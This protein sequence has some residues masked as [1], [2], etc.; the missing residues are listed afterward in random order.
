TYVPQISNPSNDWRLQQNILYNYAIFRLAHEEV[1]ETNYR[2]INYF[3]LYLFDALLDEGA[4]TTFVY[5]YNTHLKSSQGFNN[6]QLRLQMAEVMIDHID[7]L[8][9]NSYVIAGGD[10]NV[11]TSD[12]PAYQEL[13]QTTSN[14]L[15]D[16]I[17]MP[18]N[19]TDFSFPNKEILTQST[20]ASNIGDGAGGG[21]DDRFD[22]MLLSEALMNA[23]SD[24]SFQENS[25]QALGNNGTC[26]NSSI[27]ACL[28][29]NDVPISV[30]R[31]LFYMSDHLPVLLSLN[32]SIT[33]NNKDLSDIPFRIYPNPFEEQLN[34]QVETQAPFKY[35]LF[36]AKGRLLENGWTPQSLDLSHLN[37]GLYTIVFLMKDRLFYQKLM[38]I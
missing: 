26:Y 31:A 27:T 34:I 7:N 16:P 3:K 15:F 36:D 13:L 38:K 32:T 22:F 14:T 12:E 17:D 23:G 2:D 8:P 37:P 35:E 24:I 19:W 25:Y 4:D 6:E 9:E 11:Y 1:I 30:L 21:M 20:R 28:N 10:F 33:L 5:V 18:G 29:D